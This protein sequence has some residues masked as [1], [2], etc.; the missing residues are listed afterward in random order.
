MKDLFAGL[1]GFI[2]VAL[3]V[4]AVSLGVWWL[5]WHL[6]LFVVP[7]VWPTG[8]ANLIRPGY[9]LFAGLWTL[10][11]LV[12]KRTASRSREYRTKPSY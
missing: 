11:S 1:I 7:A 3:L 4:I 9:W 12:L 2:L 5:L 8:P 6:W 10:V